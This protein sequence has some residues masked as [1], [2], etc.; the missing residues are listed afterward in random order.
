[1][2]GSWGPVFSWSTIFSTSPPVRTSSGKPVLTDLRE[3]KLTLP[4]I[5]VLN[6][7]GAKERGLVEKVLEDRSCDRV[8]P[9]QIL[10]LVHSAGTLDEVEAMARARAE[11][12]RRVLDILSRGAG[13]LRSG[14]RSRVHPA[15]TLLIRPLAWDTVFTE[16]R[17]GR[18][19]LGLSRPKTP[20]RRRVALASSC[21]KSSGGAGMSAARH[22]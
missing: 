21:A 5:L 19:L 4:L 14:I 7:S 17:G 15:P 12:A 8:G 20:I 10:E 9:D 16:E 3:G 6:R 2:A 11:E 22:L 13:P 18:L 1:M